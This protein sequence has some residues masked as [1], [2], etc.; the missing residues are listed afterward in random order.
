M[1]L[2]KTEPAKTEAQV[3]QRMRPAETRTERAEPA[4]RGCRSASGAEASLT[5]VRLGTSRRT[6]ISNGEAQNGGGRGEKVHRLTMSV[7]ANSRKQEM[8]C[9][10]Q[11]HQR[12]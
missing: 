6:P 3:E 2:L 11:K 12:Q 8:A 4:A 1:Q 5:R 10:H 9:S 7:D